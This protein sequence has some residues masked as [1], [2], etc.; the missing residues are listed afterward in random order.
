[1][2]YARS[3]LCLFIIS[4]IFSQP[5]KSSRKLVWSD[6]FDESGLPNEKKW[7]YEQGYVRNDEVQYYAKKRP[8][9]ARIEE[10]YLIIES[11]LDSVEID[12]NIRPV[13]SASLVT[14]DIAEW[15][16]AR[17]EVRAKVPVARGTWP[18]IWM[19]GSNIEE[20]GWPTSGEIDIMEHVGFDPHMIHTNVHTEAYNHTS[21]TNKG[22]ATMISE[23]YNDFHVYAIDWDRDRINFYI[24]K[25]EVFS[26]RNEGTG[27]DVW[28]FDQP[29]YLIL[30]LAIGGSWG[31]TEGID[32][33][34][35]PQRF[36][37]DYVRVY[38]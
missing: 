2:I 9:N 33:K 37:V 29:F 16:Y 34:A 21:G 6:E 24:D 38:Q 11:R 32:L 22:K 25:K 20:V 36:Y 19:L 1:M 14:K 28:P 7:K 4:V 10:G 27:S 17:I 5:E 15:Q 31:G 30:N 23:P 8:E 12:G 13:T 26:F 35:L 3:L 18:A